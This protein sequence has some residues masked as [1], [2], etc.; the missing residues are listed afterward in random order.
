MIY[1]CLVAAVVLNAA[2]VF[3]QQAAPS[4]ALSASSGLSVVAFKPGEVQL[5]LRS[6]P[7]SF[8][9]GPERSNSSVLLPLVT[10]WNVSPQQVT[11]IEVIGYFDS[12]DRALVSTSGDTIESHFVYGRSARDAFRPFN[13]THEVGPSGGSL[14]FFTQPITEANRRSTRNDDLELKVD[15][16]IQRRR[17]A[18]RYVG[19]LHLEARYF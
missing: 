1:R 12:M 17:P 16:S 15:D 5:S 3:S 13:E 7:V 19:V 4:G 2:L 8:D 18:S 6:V 14:L 10:S 11:G 9:V